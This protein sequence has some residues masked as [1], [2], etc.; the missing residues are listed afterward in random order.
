VSKNNKAY[1][2]S[3]RG[4]CFKTSLCMD[5]V[6][7][8]DFN[9][10]GD[11]RVI[12]NKDK[13]FGFPMNSAVF[14]F[15]VKHVVDETRVGFFNQVQFAIEY[16]SGKHREVAENEDESAELSALF[17]IARSQRLHASKQVN[18]ELLPQTSREQIVDSLI[19][20]N[21]MEDFLAFIPGFG[22]DSA[23]FLRYML[24]YSFVFPSSP[25]TSWQ[26]DMAERLTDTLKNIP[27]YRVEIPPDYSIDTFNQIHQFIIENC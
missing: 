17:L 15:M 8:A 19:I 13:V 25:V 14:R 24:A 18:F 22:I 7:R 26:R 9:W 21:R 10:L 16:L 5:F 23:P 27:V 2:L 6:R 1:L 4:G 12:L 3:G 11:D 20:S